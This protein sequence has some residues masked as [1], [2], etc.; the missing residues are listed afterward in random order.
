MQQLRTAADSTLSEAVLEIV[1]D[2]EAPRALVF[3]MWIDDEHLKRWPPIEGASVTALT[4]QIR[5]GGKWQATTRG[6]DGSQIGLSGVFRVVAPHERLELTHQWTGGPETL[7]N[8]HFIELT[9]GKTRMHFRQ[10]GFVS[11]LLRDAH[12]DGWNRSFEQLEEELAAARARPAQP[13]STDEQRV[14]ELERVFEAPR[15]LVYRLWT[16]PQ[17]T[18]RW[19]G[20]HG[21][22]VSHS[23][24]DFRVGG[25][26]RLC[27]AFENGAEHWTHGVYREIRPRERLAMTYIND[28]DG[29]EMLVE[30]DFLEEGTRTRLK[31]RQSI[32]LS[33]NERD[34]HRGGWSQTLEAFAD[35]LSQYEGA[36][37]DE[38]DRKGAR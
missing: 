28:A 29:H 31:L 2:F 6:A 7:V 12:E 26:W 10:A 23:E 27:M 13:A 16:E 30:V 36:S 25:A 32:F 9:P 11:R 22:R 17:H 38:R 20:P 21:S 35:Y 5:N 4:M 15:E 8:I 14:L 34:G 18:A 1:R 37:A 24:M 33:I 3:D 19:W